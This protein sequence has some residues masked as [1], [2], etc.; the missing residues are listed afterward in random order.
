MNLIRCV[1]VL[2]LGSVL[3]P[4]CKKGSDASVPITDPATGQVIGHKDPATGKYMFTNGMVVTPQRD[5]L[6][7]AEVLEGLAAKMPRKPVKL[8]PGGHGHGGFASGGGGGG[9]AGGCWTMTEGGASCT[10]CCT[11][12]GPNACTCW[13]S[14]TDIQTSKG[15][16]GLQK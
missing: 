5:Q 11:P 6:I 7:P 14:C 3:I 10:G 15:G 12:A 8:A 16:G 2:A 13:E 9:C 4:S 1:L